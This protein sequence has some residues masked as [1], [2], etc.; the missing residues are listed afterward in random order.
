MPITLNKY[1]YG[2]G[3]PVSYVD[4]SGNFSLLELGAVIAK[5]SWVGALA[6]IIPGAILGYGTEIGV[7]RGAFYGGIIGSAIQIG[8]VTKRPKQVM[9]AGVFNSVASVV[10]N[11]LVQATGTEGF[12]EQSVLQSNSFRICFWSIFRSG[13]RSNKR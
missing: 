10:S 11:L 1:L 8:Y 7:L 12:D 4:P 3:N 13:D 6:G 5:K 9:L 2:N